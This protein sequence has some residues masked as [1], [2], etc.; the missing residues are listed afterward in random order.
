[1]RMKGHCWFLVVILSV[2]AAAAAAEETAAIPEEESVGL[3]LEL[4]LNSAYNFR[5]LNLFSSG[6]QM[7]HDAFVAPS[8]T[9]AVADTGFWISYWGAYQLRG[10]VG[11]NV[12]A[13]VGHEQD[14]VVGY[15]LELTDRLAGGLA[16]AAYVYPFADAA[17]AGT[18]MPLYFEALAHLGWSGPV[19]LTGNV[20]YFHGLQDELGPTSRYVYFRPEVGR[21]VEL[22]ENLALELALAYGFKLFNDRDAAP[23]RENRHDLAFS[24]A[25]AWQYAAKGY[26]TPSVNFAWTDLAG[27]GVGDEYFIWF[28]L[29]TGVDL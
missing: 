13:G 20:S 18:G 2:S 7:S 24:W 11:G 16:L 1:M 22:A 29:A 17:I 15:D 27:A 9:F 21:S 26:L 14:V 28:G 10:D 25:F 3:N 19:T 6:P 8:L 23:T 4:A 12:A 5:G